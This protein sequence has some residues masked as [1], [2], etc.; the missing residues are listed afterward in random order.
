MRLEAPHEKRISDFHPQREQF[1]EEALRGL[2]KTP[3]ELPTKYLYDEHGSELYERICS[4]K[5]YYI[6][7]LEIRI[8]EHH[9]R[10]IVGLLDTDAN[11]I[12]FGCGSCNK[13]RILLDNMP[14]LAA[15]VPIDISKKQLISETDELSKLYP[16]LQILP[17]CADF[18]QT[19]PLPNPEHP[20]K[21]NVVY[22][23]GSSIGN[24]GPESGKSLLTNIANI[25]QPGGALFIGVDLV[26]DP[27]VLYRA[28]ND[29]QG[30]TA[31][32]NLN[33]L[34]RINRE[35]GA[36]FNIEAF[37]HEAFYNQEMGRVEM[38]LISLK[39]QIVHLG[40][41]RI[42]FLRGES[43]WTESSYKFSLDSFAAMAGDAGFSV[44]K[45]WTDEKRR[46]SLQ[47][48]VANG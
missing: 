12:E 17:V 29:S 13:T 48:L 40:R 21:R 26:K 30:V 7:R 36:D 22:F 46:F 35:L 5:E 31:A 23:P 34:T 24:F 15:Y 39:D 41:R 28:Y 33:L 47:Y 20:G 8:M 4:L 2:T 38:H 1:L 27:E 43:I 42:P 6:P 25:C 9:I 11:L 3:K 18:T 32:F 45:V 10:E 37:R 44:E 19:F 14:D 16:E